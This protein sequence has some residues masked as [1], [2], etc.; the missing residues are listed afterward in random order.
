MDAQCAR[1]HAEES[2]SLVFL[3]RGKI[4]RKTVIVNKGRGVGESYKVERTFERDMAG[5][6]VWGESIREMGEENVRYAGDR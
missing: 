1:V 6:E 5:V 3:G 4:Q 2:V